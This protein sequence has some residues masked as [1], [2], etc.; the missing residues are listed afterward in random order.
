V[1]QTKAAISGGIGLVIALGLTGLALAARQLWLATFFEQTLIAWVVFLLLMAL[2][3]AEIPLMIFGLRKV[4]ESKGGSTENIGLVG[5]VA[6]VFFP[7]VYALPNLLLTSADFIWLGLL[8]A[9]T[10]LL[11]FAAAMFFLPTTSRNP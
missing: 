2:A 1:S 8:I 3:L 11:R 4:I 9:G 6:F 7:V 10:S 5:N